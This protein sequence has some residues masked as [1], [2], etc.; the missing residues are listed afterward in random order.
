MI[1]KNLE[2]L[3]AYIQTKGLRSSSAREVIAKEFFKTKDHITIEELLNKTRKLN[4]KIGIATVYRTL[5]LLQECGLA[6]RRDFNTGVVSFEPQ[7]DH[8]HDHLICTSCG[9]IIEFFFE[10]IERAQTKVADKY[11]FVLQHHKME[12]YEFVKTAVKKLLSRKK[13]YKFHD[14]DHIV[15]RE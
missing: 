8:H 14:L 13:V 2:K 5:H 1:D 4:P 7:T 15:I 10:E 3:N 12:L 9:K 6:I 11:D